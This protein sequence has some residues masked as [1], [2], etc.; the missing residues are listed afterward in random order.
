MNSCG[1]LRF[2]N[3]WKMDLRVIEEKVTVFKG[4]LMSYLMNTRW[5]YAE[6]WA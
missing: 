1:G 2:R 6:F 4:Y 3:L 5:K